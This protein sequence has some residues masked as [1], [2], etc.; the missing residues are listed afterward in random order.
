M[1]PSH[2]LDQGAVLPRVLE[3]AYCLMAEGRFV[4]FEVG[5]VLAALSDLYPEFSAE[6]KLTQRLAVEPSGVTVEEEAYLGFT[7]RILERF[8]ERIEQ[9]DRHR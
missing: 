2:E 7:K 8:F 1:R 9:S 3:G 6:I 5:H 4:N